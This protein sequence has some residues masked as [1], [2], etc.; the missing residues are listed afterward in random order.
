M[1]GDPLY[2]EYEA[3]LMERY[4]R[5]DNWN[6]LSAYKDRDGRIIPEYLYFMFAIRGYFNVRESDAIKSGGRGKGHPGDF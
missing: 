3:D 5:L 1:W 4:V 6:D 2:T